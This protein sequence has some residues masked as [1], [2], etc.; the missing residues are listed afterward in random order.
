M[1]F[2]AMWSAVALC[3]AACGGSGPAGEGGAAAQG[4]QGL[5]AQGREQALAEDVWTAVAREGQVFTVAGTQTIRYGADSRWVQ[6]TV[7]SSGSC[8]N[9]FFGSDPAFLT[10]KGC[11]LLGTAP[12]PASATDV[13]TLIAAEGAAFSVTGTL[14]VRYGL[15]SNWVQ[16]SVANSGSCS[17]EFFGSDPMFLSVKRCEV[18]SQAAPPTPTPT[19]T[20]P[21]TPAGG[22]APNTANDGSPLGTNLAGLTYFATQVPFIDIF[23]TSS[24]WISGSKA[25]WDDGRALDVGADG[26]LRSLQPGQVA[27]TLMLRGSG[28]Y[29]TGK[30]IV[31]H[32]GAGSMEY[33]FGWRKIAAES[34]QGRDVVEATDSAGNFGIY[35]SNVAPGNPLRN[36]RVIMP[37]G[38]CGND[39]FVHAPAASAC[40][41]NYRSFEDVYSSLIFYPVFLERTRKYKALRYMDWME[42]NLLNQNGTWADRPLLSDAR[43]FGQG[44]APLEVM[45][46]LANRLNASPWFN[47]P[48][49]A[50]DDYVRNFAQIV[51]DRLA[52]G[53]KA[54]I[55]YS[56]ETW[57]DS[58]PVHAYAAQ[59]AA[60]QGIYLFD[61]YTSSGRFH[62][63]RATQMFDIWSSVFGGNARLV[64]VLGGQLPSTY[65]TDV[66]AGFENAHLKA[67]AIAMNA[68][69]FADGLRDNAEAE[70]FAA[71]SNA[72]ALEEIRTKSLPPVAAE[73]RAQAALVPK[74]NLKLLAFEAGNSLWPPAPGRYNPNLIAK[75]N[76]IQRDPGMKAVQAQLLND[77]FSGGG[78]LMMHFTDVANYSPQGGWFG[79]LEYVTQ[80]REQAPK[81]DA[82][83]TFIDS[84]RNRI[85][86]P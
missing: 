60:A 83:M 27:R 11:E 36:I 35:I 77:W 19:P 34:R 69:F 57:N 22:F 65:L 8:T 13:W 3:V 29:P 73:V 55:E 25:V 52:P 21:P 78:Q 46:E 1:R 68:Y 59:Q 17:N 72:Q 58:F 86:A 76:A 41:G 7:T 9:E 80:P 71:L 50:D 15:G 4:T 33:V 79:S 70:R 82:L 84:N 40:P 26:W 56:N 67:D 31:L 38:I 54:H 23:K 28:V 63:R 47:M 20:P 12:A 32:E 64:R 66:I 43:Y 74:Y 39:P 75:L 85:P 10:V 51:R 18:L 42:T 16:R 14:T 44:G 49:R 2:V 37:G 30:Y 24:P 81:F 48:H 6:R 61:N 62:A 45:V 5:T 53:L